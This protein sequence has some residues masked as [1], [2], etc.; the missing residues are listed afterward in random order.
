MEAF[1]MRLRMAAPVVVALVSLLMI[2]GSASA[3]HCGACGF[4]IFKKPACDAQSCFSPCQEQNKV[5]Y[6]LVYD[7][8]QEKRWHTTYK[9]VQE[10]VNSCPVRTWPGDAGSGPW[11]VTVV[12]RRSGGG[13]DS[14]G[15]RAAVMLLPSPWNSGT[16]PMSP[17]P[18]GPTP[19][20]SIGPRKLASANT[21]K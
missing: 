14:T 1:I 8:V 16:R 20:M 18:S 5:V 3:Q 10:T 15:I 19:K 13:L 11:A 17:E 21:S 4:S 6:K 9:T 12:T 7:T 2:A